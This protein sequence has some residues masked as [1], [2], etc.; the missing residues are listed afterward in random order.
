M[1]DETAFLRDVAR[2][3][4]AISDAKRLQPQIEGALNQLA[5]LQRLVGERGYAAHGASGFLRE[6]ADA[7]ARLQQFAEA[8]A[9][10]ERI[11]RETA[12]CLP[13]LTYQGGETDGDGG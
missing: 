1:Q 6:A 4:Q 2:R 9:A 11:I 10:A 3:L 8:L 13:M 5:E 12:Y 7:N